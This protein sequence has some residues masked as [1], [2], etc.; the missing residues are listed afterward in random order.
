MSAAG[1][2]GFNNLQDSR[3]PVPGLGSRVSG[4][5]SGLI[6]PQGYSKKSRFRVSSPMLRLTHRLSTSYGSQTRP[7]TRGPRPHPLTFPDA[8]R[9]V[10]SDGTIAPLAPRA[11][12]HGAQRRRTARL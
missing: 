4:L 2:H 8:P 7:E 5:G 10:A 6:K 3:R 1:R 12:A 9:S 11:L